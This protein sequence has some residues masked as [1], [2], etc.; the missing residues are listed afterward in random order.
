MF[1]NLL[2]MILILQNRQACDGR[3]IYVY[4]L[5]SKFNKN[6][7]GQCRDMVPWMDLCKYFSTGSPVRI[8]QSLCRRSPAKGKHLGVIGTPG[9]LPR[10][11]DGW[12]GLRLAGATGTM[13]WRHVGPDPAQGT[14]GWLSPAPAGAGTGPVNRKATGGMWVRKTNIS[15]RF[16]PRV[17]VLGAQPCPSDRRRSDWPVLTGLPNHTGCWC[18]RHFR[19]QQ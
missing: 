3:G 16:N 18:R 15:P 9:Q 8:G 6:L 10:V 14:G 1:F 11:P 19:H 2:R 4:D 13:D 17:R 5:P 7:V 12:L